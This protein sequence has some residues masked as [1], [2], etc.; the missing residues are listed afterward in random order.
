M[1]GIDYRIP[2]MT[3]HALFKSEILSLDVERAIAYLMPSEENYKN[4][5]AFY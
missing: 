1:R 5:I 3:R 4:T 2:N